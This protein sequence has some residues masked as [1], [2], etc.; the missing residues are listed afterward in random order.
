MRSTITA[1]LVPLMF[2]SGL[3]CESADSKAPSEEP[4]TT[5]VAFLSPTEHLLRVTM[6]LAAYA[7]RRKSSMRSAPIRAR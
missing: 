4:D 7:P 3:A 6:T 1:F 2:C 5:G